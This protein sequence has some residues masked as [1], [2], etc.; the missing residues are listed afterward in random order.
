[1]FDDTSGRWISRAEVAESRSLRS[2]RRRSPSRC[3]AVGGPPDCGLRRRE[4]QG[5][6]PGHPVRRVALPRLLHHRRPGELEPFGTPPAL[7]RSAMTS[8][9]T[10]SPPCP[11]WIGAKGAAGGDEQVSPGVLPELGALAADPDP[12]RFAFGVGA[13]RCRGDGDPVRVEPGRRLG[14]CRGPRRAAAGR[15]AGPRHPGAEPGEVP[16]VVV[17][18]TQCPIVFIP[19]SSCSGNFSGSAGPAWPV[20]PSPCRPPSEPCRRPPRPRRPRRSG[21]VLRARRSAPSGRTR[22][23]R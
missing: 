17:P 3:R 4:E 15:P 16:L 6:R 19:V 20:I 1:M 10:R 5:H 12:A 2:V 7:D 21:S 22:Q 18:P 9:I 8:R 11:S 13:G 23:A 14:R